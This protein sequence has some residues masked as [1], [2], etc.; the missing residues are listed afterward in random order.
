MA[1]MAAAKAEFLGQS[2][3]ASKSDVVAQKQGGLRVVSL[4]SK[5]KKAVAKATKEVK[6]AAPKV[7]PKAASAAKKAVAKVNRPDNEE[8][9]K[10]Y[11]KYSQFSETGLMV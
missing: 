8:L 9:A 11:G 5:G 10:W 3:V 1:A 4:F 2:V 7:A 6:K